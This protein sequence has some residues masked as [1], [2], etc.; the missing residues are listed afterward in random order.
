MKIKKSAISMALI[1]V[2]CLNPLLINAI[3]NL[4]TETTALTAYISNSENSAITTAS[5]TFTRLSGNVKIIE[6]ED[7]PFNYHGKVVIFAHGIEDGLLFQGT[8]IDWK[9]VAE[10]VETSPA[11]CIYLM[12]CYSSK[13]T[14]LIK[15]PKKTSKFIGLN[16]QADAVLAACIPFIFELPITR[17]L[18]I[19][20]NTIEERGERLAN[21]DDKPEFLVDSESG[22]AIGY[23]KEY[24]KKTF[25]G[26]PTKEE[27][28]LWI[29]IANST[30]Y[31][32]IELYNMEAFQI[33]L[34]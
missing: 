11:E 2:F 1:I 34:D 25:F 32:A 16:G 12:A 26:I 15:T 27:N 9:S 20:C 24:I 21:G 3:D 28:I 18:H 13:V 33:L 31:N 29:N 10:M 5:Q 19:L 8:F 6:N 14:E 23:K 7:N 4:D 22:Y 30:G 17:N